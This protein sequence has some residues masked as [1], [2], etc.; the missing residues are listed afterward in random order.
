[1]R[2]LVTGISGFVGGQL[3]PRLVAAGHEVRGLSRRPASSPRGIDLAQADVVSGEGLAPALKGIE[4]AYY[5]IHSMEPSRDGAFQA[6]EQRAAY[7]FARAARRA[8]VRRIVYLGGIVP[9][10]GRASPHLASRLAVEEVLLGATEESTAFRASIV[11]GA[12]SRSFRFLVRLVERLPVLVVPAWGNHRTAPIDERDVIEFL[13]RAA[14]APQVAGRSLDLAGPDE[15]TYA[16]LIDLIRE[17]M[18]L[19]RPTVGL[20]RITATPIA[21][22]ISSVIAG[23]DWELIGPLME[24]LQYDL[25]PRDSDAAQLL[26]VRLHPMRRAINRALREW[27]ETEPLRAR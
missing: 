9:A 6:R 3:G 27:E 26:D 18:L 24:G 22:R 14:D 23:E 20:S 15:V 5:L 4:V 16:E 21:S 17:A 10:A 2:I 12:R 8:G 25:L 13:V 1:M 19:D 11:I 7:N